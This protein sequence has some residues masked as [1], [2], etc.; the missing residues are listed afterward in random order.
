MYPGA[1]FQQSQPLPVRGDVRLRALQPQPGGGVGPG[2]GGAAEP[3]EAAAG[4]PGTS[5]DSHPEQGKENV[6]QLCR[7]VKR[8]TVVVS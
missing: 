4:V 2:L 6:A 1:A 8:H 7:R 3:R 5:D